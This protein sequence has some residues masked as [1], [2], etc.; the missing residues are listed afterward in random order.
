MKLKRKFVAAVAEGPMA[1]FFPSL[2]V[3]AL[4]SIGCKGAEHPG[5]NGGNPP[6]PSSSVAGVWTGMEGPSPSVLTPTA[7]LELS[8][9]AGRVT[10][11]LYSSNIFP[12]GGTWPVASFTGT[13]DG[14]SLFLRD[15][16]IPLPDGGLQEGFVFTGTFTTP[17][18]LE[19]VE[20]RARMDGGPLPVYYRLD[21]TQ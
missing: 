10:G 1:K 16:S 2:I 19:G 5:G 7:R 14:G 15:V 9:D 21:R 20:V 6:P 8:E 13:R 11:V 17:N 4:V 12:D 18:R 3:G